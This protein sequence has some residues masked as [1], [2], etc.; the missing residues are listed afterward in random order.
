VFFAALVGGMALRKLGT[1]SIEQL[2]LKA[3]NRSQT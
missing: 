3:A 1:F 2:I